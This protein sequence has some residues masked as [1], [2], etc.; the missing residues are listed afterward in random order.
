M[1]WCILH[2][3]F[4]FLLKVELASL[5]LSKTVE[6]KI[7]LNVEGDE[8]LSCAMLCA[9]IESIEGALFILICIDWLHE[10]AISLNF[11]VLKFGKQK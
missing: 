2:T 11:E 7:G 6:I 9:S 3:N 4:W 5:P 8:N 1:K 10:K